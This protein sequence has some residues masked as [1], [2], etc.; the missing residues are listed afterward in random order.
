MSFK[1]MS[2]KMDKYLTINEKVTGTDD[3]GAPVTT[4]KTREQIWAQRIELSNTEFMQGQQ[5]KSNF[6]AK[7]II[8][9]NPG[10]TTTD[11]ILLEGITYEIMGKPREIGRQAGHLLLAGTI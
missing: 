3:D 2:G 9:F 11:R 5:M 6:A 1:V 7:F 8:N 10:I 4:W